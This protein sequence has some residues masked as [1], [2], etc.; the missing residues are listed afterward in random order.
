MGVNF[1]EGG[2]DMKKKAL[3]LMLVLMFVSTNAVSQVSCGQP[4]EEICGCKIYGTEIDFQIGTGECDGFFN[5][6]YHDFGSS[7][8]LYV[9]E[10]ANFYLNFL[11][12][13]YIDGLGFRPVWVCWDEIYVMTEDECIDPLFYSIDWGWINWMENAPTA[14]WICE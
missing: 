9:E 2:M 14:E 5:N 3:L 8:D 7:G 13:R 10:G 4:E 12:T 11:E 1:N 6:D